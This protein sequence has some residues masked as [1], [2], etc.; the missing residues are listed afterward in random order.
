MAASNRLFLTIEEAMGREGYSSNAPCDRTVS[1]AGFF[2]SNST[3]LPVFQNDV[4]RTS[5]GYTG[6][7]KRTCSL[8]GRCGNVVATRAREDSP[9]AITPLN[10]TDLATPSSRWIGLW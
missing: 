10:P 9:W 3:L 1:P 8:F 2:V 6:L 5:P 4:V 7:A